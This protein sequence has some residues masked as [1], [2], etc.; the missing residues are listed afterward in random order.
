MD[1]FTSLAVFVAAVDQGS[2]AAAARRMGMTPAMAG[3]H[4]AALEASL[5]PGCCNEPRGGCI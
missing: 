4:L 2:L 5:A 3:K 1:R